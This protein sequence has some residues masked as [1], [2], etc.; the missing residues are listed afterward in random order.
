MVSVIPCTAS[1][2][3]KVYTRKGRMSIILENAPRYRRASRKVKSQL[4]DELSRM[5]HYHRTYLASLLRNGGRDV[6]TP[7]GLRLI[8]DPKAS[9]VSRRGRKKDLHRRAAALA[10]PYLGTGSKNPADGVYLLC[11]SRCLHLLQ[12]GLPLHSPTTEEYP[13]RCETETPN[14]ESC[15]D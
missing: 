3:H 4:L 13:G 11:P 9:L 15:H 14:D 6:Y 2:G 8:A 7:Q 5:L 12:Q 10:H 1:F